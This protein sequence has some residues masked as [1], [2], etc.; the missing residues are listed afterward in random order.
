VAGE[1]G[2]LV[3]NT[4]SISSASQP[5]AVT[6]NN[7]F[8]VE[9]T[10][11]QPN[12]QIVKTASPTLV[13]P[14]GLVTYTITVTNVGNALA[15]NVELDDELGVFTD[16]GFHSYG[17]TMHFDFVDGA[18]PSG[19]ATGAISFDDGTDTFA[20]VPP[21]GPAQVFD[22]TVTDWKIIMVGSM[23]GDNASFSIEYEVV[24]Q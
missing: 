2:T 17:D 10:I 4:A 23:N 8:S 22:G 13:S 11:S 3:T 7:S 18:I 12:L 15:T 1:L 24:V 6:A 21:A 5:D 20:Y 16:F 19:L 14:G 9:L